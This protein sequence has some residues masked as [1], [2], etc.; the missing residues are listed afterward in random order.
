MNP[1]PALFQSRKFCIAML[2]VTVSLVTYF[3]GKYAAPGASADI[4]Y[5]LGGMQPIWIAVIYGITKEDT[6]AIAAG[7][8]PSQMTKSDTPQ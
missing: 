8:H 2:D 3:V 5:V 7:S 4:L 1:I 6:A